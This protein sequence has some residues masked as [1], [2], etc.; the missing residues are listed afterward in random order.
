MNS[1]IDWHDHVGSRSENF[2]KATLFQGESM[3]IGMNC[4][5]P[6]Q[7]QTNH[8]HEGAD[9]FYFVLQGRGRFTI[10][11]E[12]QDAEVGMLIVA[13]AGVLHGVRNTASERLSL[14]VGIAPPPK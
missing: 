8:A 6:D 9:K 11:D 10:G 7:T 1:F 13:P 5:D 2:Y 3:M 12:E 4:L 14:L